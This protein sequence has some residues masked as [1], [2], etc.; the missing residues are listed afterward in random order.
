[1]GTNNIEGGA[2]S[3]GGRMECGCPSEEM[4]QAQPPQGAHVS[5]T[6]FFSFFVAVVVSFHIFPTFITQQLC[7]LL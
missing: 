1:M 6:F 3:T 7:R 4:A 2:G 5:T